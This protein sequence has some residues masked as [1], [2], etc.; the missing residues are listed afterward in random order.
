VDQDR[1]LTSD[2]R[3]EA[4]EAGADKRGTEEDEV[5]REDGGLVLQQKDSKKRGI[6]RGNR[7]KEKMRMQKTRRMLLTFLRSTG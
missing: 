3:R 6:S 2:G 1:L 4:I 7:G 5:S